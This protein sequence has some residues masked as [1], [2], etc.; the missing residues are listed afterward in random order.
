MNLGVNLRT[1]RRVFLF[2]GP[3]TAYFG[4]FLVFLS[5]KIVMF[6]SCYFAFFAK[7]VTRQTFVKQ[8]NKLIKQKNI[9]A[10]RVF[11]YVIIVFLYCVIKVNVVLHKIFF[12]EMARKYFLLAQHNPILHYPKYKE[13]SANG[14]HNYNEPVKIVVAGNFEISK[15]KRHKNTRRA[16]I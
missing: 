7:N 16:N 5:R 11:F 9:L 13:G 3:K 15:G 8:K 2:L 12:C 1:L 14:K 4:A 6:F 10:V